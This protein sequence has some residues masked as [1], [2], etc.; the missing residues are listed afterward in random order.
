MELSII[1]P[2][3][4]TEIN[5][6]KR[7]L[8][9]VLKLVNIKYEILLIDDGSDIEKCQKYKEYIQNID[10]IR[11][12]YKENGGVSSARNL[13]IDE[14]IGKYIMFVD[15]DDIIYAEEITREHLYSDKDIIFYN[16]KYITYNQEYMKKE[17]KKNTGNVE[18]TYIVRQIINNDSTFHE[19]WGK[20]IRLDFLRRWHIKF[21]INIIQGEDVIFNIEMLMC[22]PNLY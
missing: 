19:P 16:K 7:C 8:N 9:S 12:I 11:Y 22:S 20:I 14:A 6:L 10:C 21:D 1:I 17:I 4:N 2:V 5:I 15:S 3:Y 18:W 13:G